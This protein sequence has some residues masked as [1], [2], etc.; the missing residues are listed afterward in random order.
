VKARVNI[1]AKVFLAFSLLAVAPLMIATA[2]V[3]SNY[4]DLGTQLVAQG[5]DGASSQLV[6]QLTERA[7]RLS[8]DAF[9][10]TTLI[11]MISAILVLFAA[12]LLSRSFTAP[13]NT[14]LQATRLLAKGDYDVRLE[15]SRRDEFGALALGFNRMADQLAEAHRWLASANVELESRVAQRTAELEMANLQLQTAAAKTE[16]AVRLKGEFLANLSHE[17]LTPL[18]AVL[19]YSELLVEGVY[20]PPAPRQAT[21]LIKIRE[22]AQTLRRLIGD[23]IDLLKVE[24]GRMALTVESFDP[25]ET[26]DTLCETLEPLFAARNLQFVSEYAP[27][28]PRLQTDRSKLQ[29][30]L[31]NLLSNALKF[32]EQGRVTLRAHFRPHEAQFVCEVSDTGPGIPPEQSATIFQ[33]FRQVDGSTRRRAGGAGIGLALTRQ[34]VELL[35][36][37]ITVESE[38]GKGSVFRVIIPAFLSLTGDGAPLPAAGSRPVIISIDD[39]EDLLEL[40]DATL[41]PAGY[42]VIRCTDGE[43]GL[44]RARELHPYAVTLDIKLPSRDGWSVLNELKSD[45]ETA[46]I[47]V[48]VLSVANE[49]EKGERF[50]ASAYLTKPFSRDQLIERLA[51]VGRRLH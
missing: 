29:N 14:L 32:T 31:Y 21:A 51:S 1:F 38:V 47:P 35:G 5:G 27:R 43:T 13:I 17:L 2:L 19:G 6:A 10:L 3:V 48:I 20:G 12:L 24:T 39:D 9:T 33:D 49:R 8:R 16:E 7:A 36:G 25:R 40:L 26:L 45:P 42:E 41:G 28:L 18:H 37:R 46:D 4:N 11:F 15:V 30:V 23:I 44:A 50:G 22:N 34:L